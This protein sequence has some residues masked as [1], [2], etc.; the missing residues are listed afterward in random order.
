MLHNWQQNDWKQFSYDTDRFKQLATRF[1]ELSGQSMGILKSLNP[2]EQ[3]TSL[4]TLLSQG[5]S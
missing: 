3:E 4:I 5:S 1:R 2:A